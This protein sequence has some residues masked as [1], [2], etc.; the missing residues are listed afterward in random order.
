MEAV[1]GQLTINSGCRCPEHNAAVG[2]SPTSS[3]LTDGRGCEAAD[4]G[5]TGS[6]ARYHVL[7]AAIAVGFTRIG[8]GRW[9]VHVDCDADKDPD[10]VWLYAK[11]A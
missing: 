4:I 9:F 1:I 5:V 6:R 3:H 7:R 2:G 10:V 8:I 11:G